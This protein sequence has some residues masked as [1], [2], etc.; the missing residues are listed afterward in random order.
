MAALGPALTG[1]G[2]GLFSRVPASSEP[3][4]PGTNRIVASSGETAFLGPWDSSQ[5][6]MQV[7]TAC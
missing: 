4:V 5:G 7:D 6:L 2:R 3:G 1:P